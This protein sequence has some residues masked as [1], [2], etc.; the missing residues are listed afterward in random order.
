MCP[1]YQLNLILSIELLYNIATKQEAC[2]SGT[3]T[4]ASCLV[5]ITPHQITHSSIMWHLLLPI[6]AS[7]LVNGI[8]G[9]TESTMY[10]EYLVVDDCGQ[11]QVVKDSRAVPPDIG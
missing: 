3:H 11:R 1:A 4:P 8:D 6:Y 5:R 9:W 2:T 10:A 7:D